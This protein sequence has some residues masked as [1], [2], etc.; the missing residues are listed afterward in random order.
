MSTPGSRRSSG[1]ESLELK[2]QVF[3]LV[4]I[5]LWVLPILYMPSW[6]VVLLML[7]VVAVNT[8]LVLRIDPVLTLLRPLLDHL[9]R[10]ENL[11]RPGIQALYA[12]LGILLAYVAFGKLAFVGV[13]TLAVGDSLSTLVGR[14]FG[15]TRI[16]FN[17]SK[18]WEGTFAFFVAT[19]MVL[20]AL[21][22]FREALAVSL[23][24]SILEAART[25]LDDN[26]TVPVAASGLAYLM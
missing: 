17:P 4:L 18:S 15:R 16:F 24:A 25:G 6:A 11:S 12:N 26:L 10:E 21:A 8:L 7:T 3:H 22:E 20:M 23:V 13:V 5:S 2:R 19:Y 1:S 9:E 14:S